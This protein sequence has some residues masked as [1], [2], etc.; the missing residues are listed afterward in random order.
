MKKILY[1]ILGIIVVL[2]IALY[3]VLFTSVGNKMVASIIQSQIRSI[4]GMDINVSKFELGF[5]K[6]NTEIDIANMAKFIVDG[7]LSLFSL[8]F[9]IDYL[10]KLN[11]EYLNKN[12][13][14]S[15]D[16]LSFG[17]SVFGS[18]FDFNASGRGYL[19]GSNVELDANIISFA[20]AIVNLNANGIKIEDALEFVSKP[21]YAQG[22]V[23]VN[24]DIFTK[25]QKL[26]GNALINIYNK[27]INYELV[28][29]DFNISLPK[30]SELNADVKAV[31]AGDKILAN[32]Q[33][34]NSYMN[35]IAKETAFDLSVQELNSDFNLNLKD[36]AQLESITKTKLA[37][38]VV[39]DGN[40]SFDVLNSALKELNAKINGTNIAAAT[41]SNVDLVLNA[42]ATGDK[43]QINYNA[44]L[45]SNIAKITKASGYYKLA[46][47]E[48]SIETNAKV[49]DLSKF[50]KDMS[51]TVL[52]DAKARLT[53]SVINELNANIDLAGGKI[54]AQSDGKVL[55]VKID[56]IEL[57]K[58]LALAGQP[59]YI[60]G[61]LNAKAH[62]SSLDF[63]KLNGN[64][65]AKA[66]GTFGQKALSQMLAKNFPANAKYEFNLNGNIKNSITNFD[67]FIKSDL[68]NLDSFKGEFDI[69][70]VKLNSNYV[71]DVFDLSRL[72][73]LADK[74][75]KGK[76][77]FEGTVTMDKAI[78][79]T[80]NSSNLFGGTLKATL[81]N[82]DLKADI[83]GVDFSTMMQ[84][85][86]LP[87][88]YEGKANVDLSY[89][90]L[91][92]SGVANAN[93][94]NGKLK[95]VGI[96]KTA[97]TLTKSDFS[98]DSFND[99]KATAKLS[100]NAVNLT[101]NLKS[102]RVNIGIDNGVV[103]TSSGAL[104][105]P[106]SIGVDKATF[107]GSIKGTTSNPSISIDLGSAL[108]SAADKL[109]KDKGGEKVN[110]LLDKLFK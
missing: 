74:K 58:A 10:L 35:F 59:S 42:K 16:N 41:L 68:A 57:S 45:D 85:L 93:L 50:Q 27:S 110:K 78:G 66:S 18:A 40:L 102:P 69:N 100:K 67:A 65:E 13:L 75:F 73:F 55:D 4:S 20:P 32:T 26:S 60:N 37:G 87:D 47:G 3:I 8:G 31:I 101:V 56:N 53:G 19:F 52:A 99:A 43:E 22:V 23:N 95:S 83:S 14:N 89:N 63:T 92:S 70:N 76:A 84:S 79:A 106:F 2:F 28:Q 51:G 48:F 81:N 105:M 64:Y 97:E 34:A 1:W 36:L 5:S 11:Q 109:L 77:K 86:D 107:K 21:K 88:Y 54:N 17:G 7:N 30:N 104:N 12:N 25:E 90:L 29:K 9:D 103:N 6:I 80:V 96:I 39:L 15:K 98:K 71:F 91:S 61:A 24:A 44:N 33:I 108:K 82:N 46:N 72:G 62:L 49:D 94:N 38:K